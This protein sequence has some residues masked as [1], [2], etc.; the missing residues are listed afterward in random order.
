MKLAC[1]LLGHKLTARTKAEIK[2]FGNTVPVRCSRCHKGLE[3]M[4]CLGSYYIEEL[5]EI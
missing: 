4:Y 1:K 5:E 2:A 3:V